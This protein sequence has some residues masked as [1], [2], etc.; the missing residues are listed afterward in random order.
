M[1][2][3]W[4]FHELMKFEQEAPDCIWVTTQLMKGILEFQIYEF[5]LRI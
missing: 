1:E 5:T 4:N 3:D 2:F